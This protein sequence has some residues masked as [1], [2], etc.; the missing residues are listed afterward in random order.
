MWGVNLNEQKQV[1][2]D[3]IVCLFGL[4]L[5]D[6]DLKDYVS[7]LTGDTKGQNRPK[8][9][10]YKG[11]VLACYQ[12]LLSKFVD[13]EV[14]IQL[15]WEWTDDSTREKVDEY[16]EE[17]TYDKF[18][19]FNPNNKERMLLPWTKEDM[20]VNCTLSFLITILFTGT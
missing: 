11:R 3:D 13:E 8:V 19:I 16:T 4:L 17:G 7:D 9:D 12:L 2:P 14:S 6:E 1:T 18:G 15:P 10:A 5:T 20:K